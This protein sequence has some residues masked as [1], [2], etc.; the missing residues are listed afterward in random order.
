MK[1]AKI[2]TRLFLSFLFIYGVQAHAVAQMQ[3]GAPQAGVPAQTQ[4][5]AQADNNRWSASI[6]FG[7]AIPVGKFAATN[8]NNIES[9][10]ARTGVDNNLQ[11]GY[12]FS[13]YFGVSVLAAFRTL[14]YDA[15]AISNDQINISSYGTRR[16]LA[17]P[18]FIHPIGNGGRWDITARLLGG[19]MPGIGF[20]SESNVISD[21]LSFYKA[22]SGNAFA[23]QA[24]AGL[25]Y[26]FSRHWHVLLDADFLGADFKVAK[27]VE[28]EFSATGEPVVFVSPSNKEPLNSINICLGIGARF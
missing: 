10:F 18:T 5:G 25:Q 12:Q 8:P 3:A 9:G 24:G 13:R 7:A 19:V 15:P 16:F 6:S 28:E 11:V 21:T 26:R 27:E 17:G 4:G 14:P 2:F 1:Y 23:Y 22:N 20:V